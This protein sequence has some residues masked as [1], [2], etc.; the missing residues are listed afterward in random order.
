MSCSSTTAW[1]IHPPENEVAL[2]R[3]FEG[4]ARNA[5]R[6]EEL[7]GLGFGSRKGERRLLDIPLPALPL[8]V[9][10]DQHIVKHFRRLSI[11]SW[12]GL[13]EFLNRVSSSHDFAHAGTTA[14]G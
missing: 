12:V 1:V 9:Q 5:G 4:C 2:T 11:S 8:D 14:G 3:L 10:N 7:S 6:E 13:P